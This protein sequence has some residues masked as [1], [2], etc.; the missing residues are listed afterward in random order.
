[1]SYCLVFLQEL[2]FVPLFIAKAYRETQY[3]NSM[4]FVRILMNGMG[5]EMVLERISGKT[6][7]VIP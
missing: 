1:M 3:G 5:R 2:S 6:F 7:S 4:F